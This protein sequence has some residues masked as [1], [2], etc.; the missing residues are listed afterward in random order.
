MNPAEGDD[1]QL[2]DQLLRQDDDDAEQLGDEHSVA[3]A[4]ESAAVPIPSM[5]V[6]RAAAEC[7]LKTSGGRIGVPL[8]QLV[9][10][11][12]AEGGPLERCSVTVVSD[13]HKMTLS[14]PVVYCRSGCDYSNLTL[15]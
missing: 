2:F 3:L 15:S 4:D 6:L 8:E 7:G 1:H 5:D 13:H 10:F 12:G 9:R 11:V 14:R